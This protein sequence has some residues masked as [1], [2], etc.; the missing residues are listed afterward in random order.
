MQ[1]RY[2]FNAH[3]PA[4]VYVLEKQS[5]WVTNIRPFPLTFV[6]IWNLP[7]WYAKDFTR[8]LE[9]KIHALLSRHHH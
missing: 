6:D 2:P 9:E 5:I 1:E 7:D 4:N 3:K 8:A